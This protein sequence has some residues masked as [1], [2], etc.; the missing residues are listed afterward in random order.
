MQ[1]WLDDPRHY[2]VTR[3]IG[4]LCLR[5]S[6]YDDDLASDVERAKE[7]YVLPEI[8]EETQEE[9]DF[10]A[11]EGSVEAIEE[12]TL[13][14]LDKLV[15]RAAR[16]AKKEKRNTD[17]ERNGSPSKVKK[18]MSGAPESSLKTAFS[19]VKNSRPIKSSLKATKPSARRNRKVRTRICLRLRSILMLNLFA[20]IGRRR[21]C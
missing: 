15:N 4:D 16:K 19:N 8:V 14:R 5:P 21:F 1:K 7:G 13:D 3:D 2:N 18:S 9:K 11:S 12:D 6:E 17:A 20:E 10:I